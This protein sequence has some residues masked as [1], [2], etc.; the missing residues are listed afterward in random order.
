MLQAWSSPATKYLEKKKSETGLAPKDVEIPL[1]TDSF[2]YINGKL[3]D[4]Y[5]STL[6]IASLHFK[7]EPKG[8]NGARRSL[9]LYLLVVST[10]CIHKE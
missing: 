7:F 6:R 4:G 8:D 1:P 3:I 9:S 10:C 2:D 5:S